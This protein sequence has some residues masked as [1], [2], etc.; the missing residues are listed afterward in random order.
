[1]TRLL[2]T[3][4][5]A[6]TLNIAFGQKEINNTKTDKHKQVNG[7]NCFL[8]PPTGFIDATSFQ[9][10]QQLNSGASILIME[11]P[12]PFSESTKGFNEQGLKTQ[13]VVLKKKEDIKVNGNQGLFLTAEQ[14]AHGTNFSK[15]ILVFGDNKSTFMVNGTFPKEVKELHKDIVESMFSVVYEADLIIDPLSSASFSINTDDTKLKFAKS[16]TGMLLYTVDGKVPTESTDKT[17]FIVGRSSASVQTL[18]KK[19]TSLT[20]SSECRIPN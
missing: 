3:L 20:G 14:F 19:L 2:L 7:T 8:V 1:M 5:G 15:Y 16:V 6:L 4:L 9:G 18:D 13:G 17:T 12:G 10:F 11:I